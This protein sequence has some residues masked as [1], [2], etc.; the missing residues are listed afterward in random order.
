[1]RQ[2]NRIQ[3]IIFQCGCLLMVVGVAL[4]FFGLPLIAPWLFLVGAIGFAT[5]QIAQ[6]YEGSDFTVRRLRHMML[7]SDALILVTALL[8][9]ENAYHFTLP[10]FQQFGMDGVR[11]YNQYVIHNNWVVTMLI[12]AILQIYSMHRI[13]SILNSLLVL[14]LFTSCAQTY[15]IQGSSD[16]AALDGQKLYLKIYDNNDLKNV[17]SCEVIHGQFHFGGVVDTISMTTL[18]MDDMSLLP[19]VLEEGNVTMKLDNMQR[20]VS[21]TPLNDKLAE[22]MDKYSKIEGQISDLSHQHSQAIMNGEDEE[23]VNTRLSRIADRL[24]GEEDKLV[25]SFIEEN[26]DNVLGPGVFFLMTA[27]SPYPE[28]QPWIE[29]LMSKATDY[30]KSNAYVRDFYDKAQQN[31]K[32]MNGTMLPNENPDK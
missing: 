16:L 15:N 4:N 24:L 25:T 7:I 3:T 31:E 5:M 11:N 1:M 8:M 14:A 20:K 27:G 6:V 28:L 18:F 29:A 23:V 2:L 12:A 22:F 17:D 9:V 10:L 21:G 13:S 26:F 30:F 32:M 19:V